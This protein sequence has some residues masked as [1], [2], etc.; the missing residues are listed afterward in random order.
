MVIGAASRANS[1]MDGG[2]WPLAVAE[3][4]LEMCCCDERECEEREGRGGE[5]REGEEAGCFLCP[6]KDSS[7]PNCVLHAQLSPQC[8]HAQTQQTTHTCVH[9]QKISYIRQHKLHFP[10]KSR[11]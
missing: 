7:Q 3:V 11:H 6:P 5:K 4:R 10:G 2:G 9:A 8:S 1:G